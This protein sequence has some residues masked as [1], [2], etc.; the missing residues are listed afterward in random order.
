LAPELVVAGRVL[1]VVDV[2]V[3]AEVSGD[4]VVAGTVVVGADALWHDTAARA[5]TPIR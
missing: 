4:V 3:V 2:V 1:V 5:R